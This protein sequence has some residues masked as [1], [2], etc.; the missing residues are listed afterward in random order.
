LTGLSTIVQR[1]P[2]GAL[3]VGVVL[4][5]GCQGDDVRLRQACESIVGDAHPEWKG[6]PIFEKAI[7]SCITNQGA[8]FER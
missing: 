8:G 7:N 4:G 6:Q 5:F 2:S 3:L 1:L